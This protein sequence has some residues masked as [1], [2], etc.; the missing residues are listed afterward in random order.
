MTLTREDLLPSN[1]DGTK[2]EE[3]GFGDLG[4]G[5]DVWPIWDF[6]PGFLERIAVDFDGAHCQCCGQAIRWVVGIEHTDTHEGAMIGTTCASS[7]LGMTVNARKFRTFQKRA[8]LERDVA[9]YIAANPTEAAYLTDV[10]RPYNSFMDDLASKLRMYG[11]LSEKQT[12]CITKQITRDA[13]RAARDNARAL[14]HAAEIATA[15]VLEAGRYTITGEIVG[16]KTVESD[17]GISTKIM[18]KAADGNKFWVTC[19]SA[20]ETEVSNEVYEFATHRTDVEP[21][22]LKGRTVTL[23]ATWTPA[24]GDEH[25]A[26]GKRPTLKAGA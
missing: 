22:P 10:L 13:E 15:P 21:A 6:P 14:E 3:V 20:L 5:D 18:I 4:G 7:K 17:W 8:Q 9:A 1:F 2:F 25:F 12:A 26:F 24:D 23:A 19:P 16:T 11:S